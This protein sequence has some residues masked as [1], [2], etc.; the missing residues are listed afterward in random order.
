MCYSK[1]VNNNYVT[2]VQDSLRN[3]YVCASK[4]SAESN[5]MNI[6]AGFLHCVERGRSVLENRRQ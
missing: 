4:G 3:T 1:T 6:D 2:E 5:L